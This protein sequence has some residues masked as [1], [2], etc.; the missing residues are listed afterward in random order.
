MTKSNTRMNIKDSFAY[1]ISKL[2]PS[3]LLFDIGMWCAL[4]DGVVTDFNVSNTR[5]RLHSFIVN[6]GMH[7]ICCVLDKIH[8]ERGPVTIVRIYDDL[9]PGRTRTASL[10]EFDIDRIG[11]LLYYK[12]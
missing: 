1:D 10:N 12:L 6:T 5:Y 3:W 8:T 9:S 2:S 4:M 7:Y 11:A